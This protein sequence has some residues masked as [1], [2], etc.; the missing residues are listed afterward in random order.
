MAY[1]IVVLPAFL[2]A[3][4][5][6][7]KVKRAF[8]RYSQV[9][10][11]SGQSGAESAKTMLEGMGIQVVESS[12]VAMGMKRAVAIESVEGFLTDHYDPKAKVLRLSPEVYN[13]R[14]LAS[15]G[16]ACHEAGHALQHA[17]NYEPLE[18]RNLMVPIA[19]FG[20]HAAMPMIMAGL[21]ISMLRP[22]A[23]LGV[24]LFAIIVLFQVITL[25]VE[26]NAS[27]RA[28]AAL[29]S[30]NIIQSGQEAAGVAS[31]LNAAALTYVAAAVSAVMS[32]FYYIFMA[33]GR[34]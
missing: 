3:V 9:P 5:A 29:K 23:F 17:S 24:A 4:L 32:L 26:F 27:R 10:N 7:I 15:V 13:G 16:V 2:L 25:P 8:S 1:L 6:Q 28:R 18:A 12:E 31:V 11:S 21:C 34:R 30:L 19:S 20:S 33:F 22:L 14:S